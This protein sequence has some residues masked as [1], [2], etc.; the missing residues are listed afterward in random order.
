MAPKAAPKKDKVKKPH[1]S[2]NPALATRGVGRFSRSKMYHKRGLWA[3]KKKNGGK[4]PEHKPAAKA[5]VAE[6]KTPRFYPAE[7]VPRPLKRKVSHAPT[8]LRSSITPG[9]VLI[10]LAGRFKGKRVVFLKQLPSGLLLVNGPFKLNGV[11]LKRV[12]QAYVI[13]TS[14][15]V[16]VSKADV[17]KISD[18]YFK[19]T[20]EKKAK[21]SEGDFFQGEEKKAPLAP[22]RIADQKAV[23]KVILDAISKT[24]DLKG[25]LS[26][27]FTLRAGMKPH[28][29]VF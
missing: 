26:A 21:K 20:A 11:P 28:D 7:D 15:K 12:N 16:D 4:F 29:L 18:A 27:R 1:A 10:L 22:E 23:D 9:T 6:Q 8:K 5:P 17:A 14:T 24:P 3:L 19:K 25:Y 13:A 2:R